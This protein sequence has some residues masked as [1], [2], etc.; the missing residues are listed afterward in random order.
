[1]GLSM[2]NGFAYQSH[3][4]LSIDSEPGCGTR[5]TLHFPSAD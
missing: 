4:A 3:G 1:M 5:V 2:A